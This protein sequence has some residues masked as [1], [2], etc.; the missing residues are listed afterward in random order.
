[1]LQRASMVPTA[2]VRMSLSLERRVLGA[3]IWAAH[4]VD[5]CGITEALNKLRPETFVR[6]S[7]RLILEAIAA[8]VAADRLPT[9]MAVTDEL[10]RRGVLDDVR[11]Q[12]ASPDGDLTSAEGALFVTGLL[13]EV[14]ADVLL[15]HHATE[16]CRIA[17]RRDTAQLAEAL[18][19]AVQSER[20]TPEVKSIVGRLLRFAR[21]L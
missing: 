3:L 7:H 6:R 5:S 2:G 11:G 20:P 13:N 9:I 10:R 17:A 8:V 19:E 4:G 15:P 18:V 21:P 1:M 16:L 14:F 12:V